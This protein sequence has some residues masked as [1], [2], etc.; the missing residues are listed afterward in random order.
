ME[1]ETNPWWTKYEGYFTISAT[2]RVEGHPA[3]MVLAERVRATF[4]SHLRGKALMQVQLVKQRHQARCYHT[5]R[6]TNTGDTIVGIT[7][8]HG[9]RM[10]F[11]LVK[12][13]RYRTPV[14]KQAP[15]LTPI[16]PAPEPCVEREVGP[17]SRRLQ[18]LCDVM[19]QCHAT[20]STDQTVIF[21][22]ASGEQMVADLLGEDTEDRSRAWGRGI[23]HVSGP[24]TGVVCS[25]VLHTNTSVGCHIGDKYKGNL[26]LRSA[27]TNLSTAEQA[28][29]TMLQPRGAVTHLCMTRADMVP[30]EVLAQV[31]SAGTVR[32]SCFCKPQA[33][34]KEIKGSAD[35]AVKGL[36]LRQVAKRQVYAYA[37]KARTT[38]TCY[39]YTTR[40]SE[41]PA[42]K[43]TPKSKLAPS[44][45]LLQAPPEDL[46][47]V[48]RIS[49]DEQVNKLFNNLNKIPAGAVIEK[50]GGGFN[51]ELTKE[52][53]KQI[54]RA[55]LG[56]A[57]HFDVDRPP[58]VADLGSG[59][60]K[61]L[62]MGAHLYKD[63]QFR[64]LEFNEHRHMI[65]QQFLTSNQ[66][67]NKDNIEVHHQDI[68]DEGTLKLLQKVTHMY[69]FHHGMRPVDI[70]RMLHLCGQRGIKRIALFSNKVTL[71]GHCK[72]AQVGFDV[73]NRL[74]C[75]QT[76]KV[77]M[78]A[79][80]SCSERTVFIYEIK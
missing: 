45:L 77:R 1:D 78:F 74:Q 65:A 16:A 73:A 3:L 53:Y 9:R 49:D 55:L 44:K 71:L 28:R 72:D 5:D 40:K 13:R 50:K 17:C 37:A 39:C 33:L 51:G 61:F 27:M 47:M 15:A 25:A 79:A 19:Q 36:E 75:E 23:V 54:L 22:K 10:G 64:G 43:L 80:R 38:R 35:L 32:F 18:E 69:S 48:P 30:G 2:N 34:F 4:P 42:A 7:L 76:F 67:P 59:T 21:S 14:S 31:A 11:R 63:A 70:A 46:A 8:G 62:F 66:V 24:S 29:V 52:S 20:S 68:H 57:D 58:V 56:D 26:Y 6:V 12:A 41:F 60:G